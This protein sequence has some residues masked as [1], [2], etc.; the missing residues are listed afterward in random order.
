[1]PAGSTRWPLVPW[2]RRSSRCSGYASRVQLWPARSIRSR[3][4]NGLPETAAGAAHSPLVEMFPQP[5]AIG[6]ARGHG[7][8]LAGLIDLGDA[9]DRGAR[10]NQ[11]GR[12]DLA[13]GGGEVDDRGALRLGADIA[14][15]PQP[16]FGVVGYFAR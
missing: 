10:R 11:I 6:A 14:D 16:L 13:I 15:V 5:Q 1:M 4:S 9:A 2:P 8:A 3:P 12:L 7:D